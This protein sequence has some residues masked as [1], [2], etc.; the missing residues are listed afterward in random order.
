MEATAIILII[1]MSYWFIALIILLQ[2]QAEEGADTPF[3]VMYGQVLFVTYVG[4][5]EHHRH[6]EE[7]IAQLSHDSSPSSDNDLG[8]MIVQGYAC[9]V[10]SHRGVAIDDERG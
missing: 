6:T 4:K 9:I 3:D 2:A 1:F 10:K 7:L 5:V 8:E